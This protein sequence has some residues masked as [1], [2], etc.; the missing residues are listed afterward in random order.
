[1]LYKTK[2]GEANTLEGAY[3]LLAASCEEGAIDVFDFEYTPEVR[4]RLTGLMVCARHG[5]WWY[6]EVGKELAEIAERGWVPVYSIVNGTRVEAVHELQIYSFLTHKYGNPVSFQWQTPHG[7]VKY[8]D[9]ANVFERWFV[10]GEWCDV[11][12]AARELGY[13]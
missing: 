12:K 13:E 9:H 6:E 8:Q 3:E 1:M 4:E 2:F 10:N 5:A 11:L 7:V